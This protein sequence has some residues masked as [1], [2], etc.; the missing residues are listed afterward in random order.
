MKKHKCMTID[1]QVESI[2]SQAVLL[3]ILQAQKTNY[4]PSFEEICLSN[5]DYPAFKERCRGV[6]L[7]K[8]R[9]P[10]RGGRWL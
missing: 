3:G 8:R 6:G 9:N 4:S 1:D 5:R 2:V 10:P 7:R